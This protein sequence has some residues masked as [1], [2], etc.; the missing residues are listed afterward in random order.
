MNTLLLLVALTNQLTFATQL[1]GNIYTIEP[2]ATL[3]ADCQC[4]M[5]LSATRSGAAGQST[6]NQ[7]SNVFIKANE[8][9]TLSRLSMNIDPG[10]SVTITV[11]L[12]DGKDLHLE[13]QW[14][15]SGKI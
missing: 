9:K 15:P 7:S 5:K 8:A 2:V 12:T 6:S 11:T 10:D 3:S 13:K 14:S 1:Q 4:S